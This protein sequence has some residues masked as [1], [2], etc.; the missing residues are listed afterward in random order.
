M[1]HV[2][3]GPQH[4]SACVPREYERS[5]IEL[6]LA[7]EG[8][9]SARQWA[10]RTAGL[11]RAAVLNPEHFAHTGARRRQFIEAYLELKHFAEK[12]NIMTLQ[13]KSP[14]FAE[15][16][17]IPRKYTRDGDNVSPPLQWSGAPRGTRSF[18]LLCEDPDAPSGTFRHWAVA[19]IPSDK[20]ALSEGLG[21]DTDGCDVAANDFGRAA[22]DGPAPPRGHGLHHYHFRLAALDVEAIPVSPDESATELWNAVRPHIVAEAQTVGTYQ[23]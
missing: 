15:G 6:I 12:G 8:R 5:R 9:E 10:R 3:I 2:A 1:R 13:L 21:Q 7:K 22:Y 20:N 17:T 16:S 18:A 14:A 23:R 4:G 19:N 11:Y